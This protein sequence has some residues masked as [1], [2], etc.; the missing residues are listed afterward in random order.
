M[1]PLSA[2]DRCIAPAVSELLTP[3]CFGDATDSQRLAFELHL[4]ECDACWREFQRLDSAVGALRSDMTFAHTLTVSEISGLLGLSARLEQAFGGHLSHA[5]VASAICA[6]LYAVPVL[7][8]VAYQWEQFRPTAVVAAPLVFLWGFGTTLLALGL[9]ARAVRAGAPAFNR[10]LLTMMAA[11]IVL[12]AALLPA[13]PAGPTVEAT[14]QTYPTQLGYVK[15][16]FYAWLTIPVFVLWPYH[17]VLTAQR[18][19]ADGRHKQL[20]ALLEDDRGAVPPRGALFP[21]LW[22]LVVALTG[23]LIFNWVGVSHLFEHLLPSPHR[24]F[25]MALVLTRVS[26]WLALPIACV[27]WYARCLNELKREA[28]SVI[29][30]TA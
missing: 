10:A 15:S 28:V 27:V 21:R 9:Q 16:V 12:C 11:A 13:L 8:E 22:L 26:L 20:M 17:F 1:P 24:G 25:F 29:A 3:Y 7:V 18:D 30:F 5:V 19:L 14:F 4:V 6:G 2:D 23:L